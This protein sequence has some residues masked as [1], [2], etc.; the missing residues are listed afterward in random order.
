M[1]CP[2][3]SSDEIATSTHPQRAFFDLYVLSR[4]IVYPMLPEQPLV[5]TPFSRD[6]VRC[7][8]PLSWPLELEVSEYG[9]HHDLR[10][11]IMTGS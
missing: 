8:G 3:K 5:R 9:V 10:R 6:L 4:P 7:A 11:V 1:H 2:V